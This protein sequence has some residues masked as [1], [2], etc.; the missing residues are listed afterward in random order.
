MALYD[1]LEAAFGADD[2]YVV[3][4]WN[5][6][7]LREQKEKIVVQL[8]PLGYTGAAGGLGDVAER[9]EVRAITGQLASKNPWK[10]QPQKLDELIDFVRGHPEYQFFPLIE[11]ATAG[12]TFE[13]GKEPS[14]RR[15]SSVV[16]RYAGFTVVVRDR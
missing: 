15:S 4:S 5:D 12:E 6:T 13:F 16:Q 3:G 8:R 1:D 7:P 11:P 2:R 14:N 9:V 10:G